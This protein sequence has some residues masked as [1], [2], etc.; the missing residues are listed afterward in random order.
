LSSTGY[1]FRKPQRRDEL[2][3]LL[4]GK[5]QSEILRPEIMDYAI[6]QF[7]KQLSDALGS[8]ADDLAEMRQRKSRLEAQVRRLVSAVAE[9]GH[10]RAMLEELGRKEAELQAIT[11]QLLS[12]SPDSIDSRIEEIRQFVARRLE[13][14]PDVPRKDTSLKRTEILKVQT[15]TAQPDSRFSEQ[16]SSI[17]QSLPSL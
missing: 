8:I 10:S 9:S 2:E 17:H 4:L 14:I 7:R 13:N 5:L 1:A 6:E 11:D 3:E 16:R 15:T 12:S